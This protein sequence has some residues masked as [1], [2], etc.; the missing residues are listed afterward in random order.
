VLAGFA[1][2]LPRVRKTVSSEE[3]EL[4]ASLRILRKPRPRAKKKLFTAQR[5]WKQLNQGIGG[6]DAAASDS[7][8]GALSA[9]TWVK[10]YRE[11]SFSA[12]KISKAGRQY[13]G[14]NERLCLRHCGFV[15]I[16]NEPPEICPVCKVPG[17]KISMIA[18]EAV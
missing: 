15:Y 7:D 18:K 12:G 3:A 6:E 17:L 14:W 13:A 2:T 1:P 5:R 16:G 9:L 10:K 4:W 11:Y 8:R